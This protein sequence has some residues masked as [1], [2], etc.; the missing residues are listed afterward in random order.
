MIYVLNA[1]VVPNWGVFEYSP[2]SLDDVR[3]L[4]SSEE[5]VSAVGHKATA[6]V[7][8]ALTGIQIPVNRVQIKMSVGDISIIFKPAIRLEEGRIL[9]QEELKELPYELGTLKRIK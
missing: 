8:S 4:L 9:T 6:D 3:K 7:L 5:F 1:A 2:V